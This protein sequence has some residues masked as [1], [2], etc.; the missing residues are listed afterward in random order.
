MT[1]DWIEH[2][3]FK[4][5]TKSLQKTESTSHHLPVKYC[6][7]VQSNSDV[8]H[9]CSLL[10]RVNLLLRDVADEPAWQQARF[11]KKLF[12]WVKNRQA[13]SLISI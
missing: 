12:F 8:L 13:V 5:A 3:C 9:A 10:A 2:Q 4:V 7:A 1:D 11:I 6:F